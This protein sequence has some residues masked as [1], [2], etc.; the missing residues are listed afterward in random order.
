MN[1]ELTLKATQSRF[2][3]GDVRAHGKSACCNLIGQFFR[4]L[5]HM[6]LELER[7]VLSL[8]K[9]AQILCITFG[10]FCYHRRRKSQETC[11]LSYAP[12]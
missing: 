4:R 12:A 11:A 2:N 5:Q 1:L 7:L 3:F 8:D 10:N 6:S 9:N